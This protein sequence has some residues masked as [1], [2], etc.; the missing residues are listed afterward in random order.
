MTFAK[1]L[2]HPSVT[3]TIGGS[4]YGTSLFSLYTDRDLPVVRAA[5]RLPGRITKD[6]AETQLSV[7]FRYNGGPSWTA[8]TGHVMRSYV[9]RGETAL[10][11]REAPA[12]F[13]DAAISG[14]YR[15]EK[16]PRILSDL[17]DAGG[18]TQKKVTCPSV[19]IDRFAFE[20]LPPFLAIGRLVSTLGTYTDISELRFFFDCAGVFRFGTPD[21]TGKNEGEALSL[22]DRA[23]IL[24]ERDGALETL[25]APLRHSQSFSVRGKTVFATRTWLVSRARHAH[26]EVW[27]E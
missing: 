14:S 18:I 15:Q 20:N 22:S 8:Y 26:L 5:L 7:G 17:L 21:D 13:F 27:Y 3:A 10:I 4:L 23:G 2:L 11:L 25:P 19:M 24:A 9:D 1:E 6:F 16:A 12:K